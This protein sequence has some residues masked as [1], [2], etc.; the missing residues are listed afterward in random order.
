MD[1]SEQTKAAHRNQGKNKLKHKKIAFFKIILILK[2]T[3]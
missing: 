2:L 1:T 3:D